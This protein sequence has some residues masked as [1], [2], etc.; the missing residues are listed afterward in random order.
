[1]TQGFVSACISL[2]N[3]Q[4]G[5]RGGNDVILKRTSDFAVG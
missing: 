3:Q 2:H 1:M 4:S 5:L